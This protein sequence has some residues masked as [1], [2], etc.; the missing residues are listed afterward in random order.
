MSIETIGAK[1]I[2]TKTK[3]NGWFGCD[4]NMNIYRGCSHGCIYCDSR[5]DCYRVTDFDTVRAKENALR[6]ISDD[7]RRK[8]KTGVVATGAMSDPY[9]L[10]EKELRLT[11]RALELIAAY[12]FGIAI[13]TKSDLITRDLDILQEISRNAPALCKLT[14]TTADDGLCRKIEPRALFRPGVSPPFRSLPKRGFFQASC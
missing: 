8:V 3:S 7:L 11:R 4:Y 13:D 5:S 10:F 2:V 1:T 14:I 9:N 6:I 12:G